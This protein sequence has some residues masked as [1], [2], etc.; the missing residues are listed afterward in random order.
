MDEALEMGKLAALDM[1]T[2]SQKDKT[3]RFCQYFTVQD[4]PSLFQIVSVH[5]LVQG[6]SEAPYFFYLNDC[7]SNTSSD[8][9]SILDVITRHHPQSIFKRCQLYPN[10]LMFWERSVTKTIAVCKSIEWPHLAKQ[11]IFEKDSCSSLCCLDY[12]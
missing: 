1:I 9:T 3:I 8:D 4:T 2:P 5:F 12:S 7:L 10:G 6:L 11:T